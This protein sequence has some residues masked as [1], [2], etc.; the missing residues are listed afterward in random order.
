MSEPADVKYNVVTPPEKT[1]EEQTRERMRDVATV[2]AA[3]SVVVIMFCISW[4]QIKPCV[5][6]VAH[7]LNCVRIARDFVARR[8]AA[9]LAKHRETKK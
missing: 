7:K 1:Y 2:G 8:K 6:F 4:A 5:F 3:V 9:K